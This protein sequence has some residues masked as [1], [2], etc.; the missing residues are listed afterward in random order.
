MKKAILALALGCST[1]LSH[2]QG[3]PSTPITLLVP[4]PAG[5]SSDSVARALAPR[6]TERLGQ[7]VIVENKAGAGGVIGAVQAKRAPADGRLFFVTALG[8]LVIVPHLLKSPPYDP[9]KDFEPITVAVQSPNVL[10][11]PAT[12]PH[13]SVADVITFLKSHPGA[14]TFANSG[15]GASDHLTAALFWQQTGTT[16]SHVPYKGGAPA[17]QEL[18]GGQTDAS[19]QNVNAVIQ[20]IQSGKL[21]ALAVTGDKRSPVLP[22]IPTMAEAGVPNLV[23]YSWQAVVAPRGLPRDIAAKAHAAI[24]ATLNEPTIR[25]LFLSQGFDIVANAPAQF[26]AFQQQESARWKRVIEATGIQPE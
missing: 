4:Y 15:N 19:F 16:G 24:V 3:W 26:E 12:S 23:V 25:T 22:A 7:P 9:L 11:V 21:R 2:A 20:H 8:P 18:I 17:I 14:M 10:V 5:G 1:L 13:K 6:L